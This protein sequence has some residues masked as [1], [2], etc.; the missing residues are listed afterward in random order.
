MDNGISTSTGYINHL[1]NKL[2]SKPCPVIIS[3][4]DAAP[5]FIEK[6]NMSQR[7]YKNLKEILKG[8]NVNLPRYENLRDYIKNLDIG[9]L[10]RDPTHSTC[11]CVQS[12]LKDT[13]Q[14]IINSDLF[15][16]A[17]FK[18]SSEQTELIT[19]LKHK[20][21]DLYK[22][23]DVNKKWSENR[24]KQEKPLEIAE[25]EKAGIK[26]EEVLGKNPSHYTSVFTKFQQENK[27]Q[28]V[29]IEKLFPESI[30]YIYLH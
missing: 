7:A 6:C 19:F 12:D 13:L 11:M 1:H 14:R 9:K 4:K 29:S 30:C 21:N 28:Y 27:G 22:N 16:L 8:Q 20:N 17:T 3:E 26:A 25:M 10:N 15:K 5:M 23:L 24:N 18:S 2:K